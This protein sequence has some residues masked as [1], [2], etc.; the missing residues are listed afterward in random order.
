MISH[1]RHGDTV[2]VTGWVTRYLRHSDWLC[3]ERWLVLFQ[4]RLFLPSWGNLILVT[5][6]TDSVSISQFQR[7][8][9]LLLEM[10][11]PFHC[12]NSAYINHGR[13]PRVLYNV[14]RWSRNCTKIVTSLRVSRCVRF[15]GLSVVPSEE[16]AT[17]WL[18]FMEDIYC[19]WCDPGASRRM[20]LVWK[21]RLQAAYVTTGLYFTY[22][23]DINHDYWLNACVW[24]GHRTQLVRALRSLK[25]SPY[26]RHLY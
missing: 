18:R 26:E 19:W 15:Q 22:P 1:S 25:W 24:C 20:V 14:I 8:V 7:D 17:A 21:Q 4:L 2:F 11:H 3:C 13:S 5:W 10:T 23:L 12:L 9:S 16:I 6:G